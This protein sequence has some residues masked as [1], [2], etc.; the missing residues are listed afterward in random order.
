MLFNTLSKKDTL[1]FF[2]KLFEFQKFIFSNNSDYFNL[3]SSIDSGLFTGIKDENGQ[4]KIDY[5]NDIYNK[6][7]NDFN[8]LLLFYEYNKKLFFKDNPSYFNNHILLFRGLKFSYE[9]N[10]TIFYKEFV[11]T[12]FTFDYNI[13]LNFAIPDGNKYFGVILIYNFN[14]SDNFLI[15]INNN[16][17]LNESEIIINNIEQKFYRLSF[18]HECYNILFYYAM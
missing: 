10:P 14:C 17:S 16:N 13:A 15:N 18:M 11:P 5:N 1:I 7:I 9:P 2:N 12:S 4:L 3:L 8:I 6:K